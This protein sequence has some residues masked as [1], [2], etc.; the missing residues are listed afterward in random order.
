MDV[1]STWAKQ[2]QF[3]R[4]MGNVLGES[5]A[6]QS[7]KSATSRHK[8]AAGHQIAWKSRGFGVHLGGVGTCFKRTGF[9]PVN[10]GREPT[11]YARVV[12]FHGFPTPDREKK[13]EQVP[14]SPT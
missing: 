4:P 2:I 5:L 3:T 10:F 8:S 1:E 12:S 14:V 9:G 13:K 7:V 11:G 6:R